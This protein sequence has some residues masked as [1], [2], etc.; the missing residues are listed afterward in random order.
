MPPCSPVCDF[1]LTSN[2]D[3]EMIQKDF[4]RAVTVNK[5]VKADI[6]SD[7]ISLFFFWVHSNI[8]TEQV[9]LVQKQKERWQWVMGKKSALGDLVDYF[10]YVTVKIVLIAP[11]KPAAHVSQWLWFSENRDGLC[12]SGP[13]TTDSQIRPDCFHLHRTKCVSAVREI[14]SVSHRHISWHPASGWQRRSMTCDILF[15]CHC[16][17]V[18]TEDNVLW[19]V[20]S[21]YFSFRIFHAE[22]SKVMLERHL[23]FSRLVASRCIIKLKWLQSIIAF[24]HRFKFLVL[25][26]IILA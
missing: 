15:Q 21:L 18:L 26:S 5:P 11:L 6:H 14:G 9:R 19:D 13:V 12:V 23:T 3:G 10:V 16:L 22:W 4:H 1:A 2:G 25:V 24:Y 8:F 17:C 7:N 20:A